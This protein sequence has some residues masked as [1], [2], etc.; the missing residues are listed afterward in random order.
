[1]R[2]E[3]ESSHLIMPVVRIRWLCRMVMMMVVVCDVISMRAE[4]GK[5]NSLACTDA[6][7]RIALARDFILLRQRTT[8]MS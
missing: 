5:P 2:V 6:S 1:M 3:R 7:S 4:E 8:K